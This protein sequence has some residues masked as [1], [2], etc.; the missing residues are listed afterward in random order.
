MKLKVHFKQKLLEVLD[1]NELELDQLNHSLTRQVDNWKFKK[2][3]MRHNSAWDGYVSFFYKNRFIPLGLWKEVIEICKKF[4]FNY[5][6]ENSKDI[7]D[8]TINKEKFEKF[9]YDLLKGHPYITPYPYQIESAYKILKHRNCLAELA[10]SAGKSL[11]FYMVFSWLRKN[12]MNKDDKFLVIVPNISLVDQLASDIED[13]YNQNN[14]VDIRIQQIYSGK[15]ISKNK[16]LVIGTYQSLVKKPKDY[17]EDFIGVCI[18]ESHLAKSY[19][20]KT[21]LENMWHCDYRF[22]MSGTF[23]KKET[24]DF[25]SI[26]CVTGPMVTKISAKELQDKEF[27]SNCEI[28]ILRMRY[29]KES[30]AKAFYDLQRSGEDGVK[31]LNYEKDFITK[32]EW[33][34]K[35]I[36]GVVKKHEKNQ[37]VLFSS[38]AKKYGKDLEEKIKKETNKEVYYID[39]G[40]NMDNRDY[41]ISQMKEGTGKV[42][43]ASFGT[44]STGLSIKNLHAIHFTESFKSDSIIRQSIGRG[45]RKHE[46]KEKVIIYDYVDDIRY[47][48]NGKYVNN[49][50]YNHGLERIQTYKEQQFL[51]EVYNLNK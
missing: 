49:K 3:K 28:K 33:R 7:I 30:Q 36:T 41:I 21:I 19:S 27:I 20:I 5:T 43:V 40:T 26:S 12:K 39:G 9:C 25:Y 8:K 24:L 47:K 11:I 10:T 34:K 42:L 4:N 14:Q 16:N 32:S 1:C 6:I 37:L 15:K 17:F 45:L 23:P 38:V 22:G 18:D 35:I 13:D 31:M 50:L 29:C 51:Y 46:N 48:R 2:K 44:L